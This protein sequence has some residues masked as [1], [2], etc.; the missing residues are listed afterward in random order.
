MTVKKAEVEAEVGLPR[1]RQP[2][3][4]HRRRHLLEMGLPNLG[5]RRSS[6]LI[7]STVACMGCL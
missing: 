5:R 4:R 6:G 1:G 2:Q 7:T 3:V